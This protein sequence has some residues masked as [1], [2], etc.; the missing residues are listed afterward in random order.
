MGAFIQ[1][2]ALDMAKAAGGVLIAF[3]AMAVAGKVIQSCTSK[4]EKKEPEPAK[5]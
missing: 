3:G 5:A 1:A 4:E 2:I